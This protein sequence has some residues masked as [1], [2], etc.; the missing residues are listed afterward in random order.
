MCFKFPCSV[1]DFFTPKMLIR[2]G[3]DLGK[4]KNN[5]EILLI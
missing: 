5:Y 1:D 3:K 2:N 4:Q